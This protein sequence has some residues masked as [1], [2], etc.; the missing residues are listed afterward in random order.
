M[1]KILLTGVVILLCAAAIPAFSQIRKIP[2]IVEEN[3]SN[4]YK[5]ASDIEFK[6]QLVSVDVHFKL[7]GDTMTASYSNKG[8]WKE[9]QKRS[10][11]EE[12][13]QE[14]QDGF[15]KSRYADREI[16]EATTIFLPG[17]VTQYRIKA[18]KNGV[19]KKYLYF[20]TKGRLLRESI[21]L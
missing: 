6:D 10:T 21:T 12:F 2:K 15:K 18:K 14:V 1:K 7:E 16:D 9:T 8:I 5:G 4:Q 11:F 19:E 17:D 13:P 3:F 20:N